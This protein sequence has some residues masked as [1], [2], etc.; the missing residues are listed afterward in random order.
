MPLA[1]AVEMIHAY[2]LVHDDLPAMDDDDFRRGRKTCHKQFDEATAILAGDGL[3]S[4][5]FEVLADK[6]PDAKRFRETVKLIAR[7]IGP[8]GMVGGQAADLKFQEKSGN[9]QFL[10]Q[11][12]RMKTGALITACTEAGAVWAGSSAVARKSLREYGQSIG[13]L[14]QL[15]DDIIDADGFA[16]LWGKEETYRV[17]ARVRDKAM[18]ALSPFGARGRV[19][20]TFAEFLYERKE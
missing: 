16:S 19:L 5:A 1:C 18:K 11:V 13:F 12:N 3:M 6:A 14:F 9:E 8:H 2:S 20:T 10:T 4:L 17:A 15:V 7:A